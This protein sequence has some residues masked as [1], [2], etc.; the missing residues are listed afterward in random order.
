MNSLVG[1]FALTYAVTWAC[2]MA[3]SAVPFGSTVAWMHG[4]LILLGVFAPSLV[5]ISLTAR[6]D[7]RVGLTALLRRLFQWRAPA[8]W[9]LFAVGYMAAIKLTVALVHRIATGAWPHFGQDAWYTM[10]A[11]T[12]MSTVVGGQAGEEIGWRGYALPRLESRVGLAYGSVILG[13]LWASWHLPLVFMAL[14][15]DTVG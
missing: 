14:G 4:P 13:V 15:A 6:A 3:A 8:R 11:A 9:Y 5:A 1:F 2:W 12:V 10:V 7:G